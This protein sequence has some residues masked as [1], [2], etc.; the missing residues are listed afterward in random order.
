MQRG[1]QDQV[2][3]ISHPRCPRQSCPSADRFRDGSAFGRSSELRS[4]SSSTHLVLLLPCPRPQSFMV[5]KRTSP[6]LHLLRQPQHRSFL[7]S[8]FARS[9]ASTPPPRPLAG[10][11]V[12]SL[13]SLS[14][15]APNPPAS[16]SSPGLPIATPPLQDLPPVKHVDAVT[17]PVQEL[18]PVV[19]FERSG[20]REEKRPGDDKFEV[21]GVK[22]PERPL[23]PGEE[24]QHILPLSVTSLDRVSGETQDV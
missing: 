8:T 18:V 7:P 9:Y 14:K 22:V 12:S 16:A 17:V 15:Y 11:R 4:A 21:E 20:D 5:L 2:Y 3:M 19:S 24:G 23:K 6:L 1:S 10:R 13:N